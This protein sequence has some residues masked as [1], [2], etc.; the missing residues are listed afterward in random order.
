M[1]RGQPV[2]DASIWR[3]ILWIVGAITAVLVMLETL[4]RVVITPLIRGLTFAADLIQDLRG[5][6]AREGH[7]RV[8]GIMEMVTDIVS[9]QR[10]MKK[11]V[12]RL[13]YHTGNGL[14]PSLRVLVTNAAK[15]GEKNS[16]EIAAL[17]KKGA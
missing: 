5:Q 17:K 15:V 14:E 7:P 6:E 10:D 13:E 16:K 11:K 1:E 2:D 8:P 9:E 4:R 3:N 12:E